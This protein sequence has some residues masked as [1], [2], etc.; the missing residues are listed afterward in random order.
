MEA[1]R[2]TNGTGRKIRLAYENR[3][4]HMQAL[5][6]KY[7]YLIQF[8]SVLFAV[9]LPKLAK[10]KPDAGSPSQTHVGEEL[11]KLGLE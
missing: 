2:K 4:S 11:L 8:A 10:R 3:S 7:G 1:Y 6:Q 9:F 5:E